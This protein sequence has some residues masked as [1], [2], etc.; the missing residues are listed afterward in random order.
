MVCVSIRLILADSYRNLRSGTQF[1]RNS[2]IHSTLGPDKMA[3]EFTHK[4]YSLLI[5]DDDEAFRESLRGIFE[6]EGFRTF[7]AGSGEE[8]LD[9][10][11]DQLVHLVLLDQNLPRMTGLQTLR[12]LRQMKSLLPVI[13]LTGNSTQQLLHEA[14]SARAFCVISKPVDRNVVV[15]NV[16]RALAQHYTVASRSRFDEP[17][18]QRF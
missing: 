13:L 12:M 5:T 8:A 10:I 14:L 1:A 9:I 15:Y 18:T 16:Q 2:K 6:P 7:L 3:F 11:Q 17:R 4:S